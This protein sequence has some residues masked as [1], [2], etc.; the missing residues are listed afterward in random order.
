MNKKLDIPVPRSHPDYMKYYREAQKEKVKKIHDDWAERNKERKQKQWREW[1][2]RNKKKQVIKAAF[3][4]AEKLK[5]MPPWADKKRIR[6]IYEN[7]PEGY[8]VDHII[9][10][11]GENVSGLHIPENLQYLTAEENLKKSNKWSGD[12]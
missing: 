12:A 9:P 2:E 4:K 11:R 10:L 1:Y 7:C 3:E 8:H 6:E 5:R